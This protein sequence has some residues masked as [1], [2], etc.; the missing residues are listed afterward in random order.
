MLCNRTTETRLGWRDG[1]MARDRGWEETHDLGLIRDREPELSWWMEEEK[2]NASPSCQH[3]E[4]A[5]P[6][7]NESRSPNS[8]FTHGLREGTT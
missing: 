2:G 8:N 6:V 5:V 4:P 1:E 7:L 3:P